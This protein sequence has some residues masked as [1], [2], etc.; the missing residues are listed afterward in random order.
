MEIK[1]VLFDFDYTLADSSKGVFDCVNYALEKMGFGK[2]PFTDVCKTIGM[3]LPLTFSSLTNGN[4]EKEIEIFKNLFIERADQVMSE[5]TQLFEFVPE[6]LNKL[7]SQ[8]LTLG[9]VSTKFRYRIESILARENLSNYFD[10]IVG[11]EDVNSHKPDP[12]GL[13]LAMSE[14]STSPEDCLYV[15]DSCVDGELS[16]LGNVKFV[17]VC[18]GTTKSEEFESFNPLFVC[19]SLKQL[20]D[21]LYQ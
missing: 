8:G 11:G 10:I 15:G 19:D 14:L 16:V 5:K 21:Q 17:G 4:D 18:T 1:I 20:P 7:K 6:V 3:S 2:S 13:N 9:I 12:E